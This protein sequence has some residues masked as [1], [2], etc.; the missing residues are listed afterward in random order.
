MLKP[1]ILFI[2][3][4]PPAHT[5]GISISNQLNISVLSEKFDVDIIEEKY[6]NNSHGKFDLK[7]TW[8]LLQR[9]YQIKVYSTN[10]YSHLY[11]S[12]SQNLLGLI[13]T[14][15]SLLVFKKY[16]PTSK[17]VVHIHRSDLAQCIRS[18]ISAKIFQKIHQLTNSFVVLSNSMLPLLAEKNTVLLPNSI[19]QY[20]QFAHKTQGNT[21]FLF[22][23]NYEPNKGIEDLLETFV[24]FIKQH[25]AAQL[26]CYGD[27]YERS[28][29]EHLLRFQNSNIRIHNGI[30]GDE[31][32]KV[33]FDADCLVL[34]SHNE[35]RP[36]VLLEAMAMK[37]PI[38]TSKVGFIAEMI[39]QRCGIF[40]E[41]K[42]KAD[43]FK[44]LQEF[45]S[46]YD[47]FS[48]EHLQGFDFAN[49]HRN[50]LL[51]IFEK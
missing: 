48:F 42:N 25:P 19:G 46:H 37:T 50:Q 10:T 39:D 15:L 40:F 12:L 22:L 6:L 8:Y 33:I 27:Y 49:E 17:V 47:S 44:S 3:E 9:L 7:K 23:S 1:K 28:F 30:Y 38:I 43:L 29:Y 14:W 13:K 5:N 20:P 45:Q 41:A 24:S 18:F 34:P 35:G 4:L 51:A 36:I 32:F 2:G 31:K 21:R 26:D 16:N 11:L